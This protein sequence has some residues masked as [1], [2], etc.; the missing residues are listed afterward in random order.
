MKDERADFTVLQVMDITTAD[1]C[2]FDFDEDFISRYFG[3]WALKGQ[4]TAQSEKMGE[5][6]MDPWVHVWVRGLLE[7][8]GADKGS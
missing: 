1:T 3:D 4:S 6:K 2:A 5:E 8:A 7:P